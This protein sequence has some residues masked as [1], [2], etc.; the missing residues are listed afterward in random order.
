MKTLEILGRWPDALQQSVARLN[1]QSALNSVLWFTGSTTPIGLIGTIFSPVPVIQYF[2]IT[3]MLSGPVL[4]AIGFLTLLFKD[5]DKLRSESYE[6]RKLALTMIEEKGGRI[7]L[8][9]T[10]VE[11][12]SNLEHPETQESAG[13]K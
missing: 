2:M 11:A 8:E 12:I 6:L 5:P 9:V 1:V 7:P 10:S 13:R 4:F 3:L